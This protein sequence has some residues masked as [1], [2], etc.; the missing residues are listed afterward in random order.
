MFGIKSMKGTA[1]SLPA[2]TATSLPA[3]FSVTDHEFN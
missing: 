3:A 1:T 2:G